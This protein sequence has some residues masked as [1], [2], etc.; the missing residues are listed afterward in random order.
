MSTTA[1]ARRASERGAPAYRPAQAADLGAC[2]RIW[3]AGLIDYQRRLNQPD[4][5]SDL[6]PLERFLAHLLRT[7]PERYWV[8]SRRDGED[9]E[10]IA[11]GAAT[12][13]GSVWFLGM[14]FVHPSEQSAGIGRSLM[15][16]CFPGGRIPAEIDGSSRGPTILGTATDSAQPISNALYAGFGMV[17]RLPVFHFVGRPEH[18]DRLPSL[19]AGVSA[20]PFADLTE[21]GTPGDDD[22]ALAATIAAV[23]RVLLGFDHEVDHAFL[24][25]DGRQGWLY[26]GNDG[27]VLGYGYGSPVGRIGPVAVV[28]EALLA[29]AV[30]HLLGA[31][32][33]RG[34][35]SLWIPGAAAATFATLLR[36]GLRIEGFPALL[37]WTRPFAD[38]DRYLP[39]SLALI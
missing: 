11:F 8:A 29:P 5:P 26:R 25:A 37:C 36:S 4:L 12:I 9:E 38:F 16:R 22:A 1:G 34:A 6:G 28:D 17:P 10:L 30:G 3:E 39:I 24:R 20:T 15:H 14:L 21:G 31:I 27:S 35:S 13:R 2:T 23:D 18:A 33:P 19:P 7:D 32:A